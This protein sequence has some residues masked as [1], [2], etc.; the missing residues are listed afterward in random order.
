MG[1][2]A[3][4]N[5]GDVPAGPAELP[6][7][8]LPRVG[9]FMFTYSTNRRTYWCRPWMPWPGWTTR[10]RGPGDRQ[11]GDEAIYGSR[12][13]SALRKL[14][15]RFRFFH[16][17]PLS[18]FKGRRAELLRCDTPTLPPGGRGDRQ[19]LRRQANWLRELVPFLEDPK[20]AIVQAPQDYR[21]GDET[22]SGNV[23]CR[24][25]WVLPHRHGD[26]PTSATRSFSTAP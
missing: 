3:M 14:G 9:P 23:Q 8:H 24:V 4:V 17:A 25:S 16:V 5:S 11:P 6:E 19:R 22:C 21:D 18:G 1:R 20:M 12:F 26:Q 15:A 2:G 13:I 7:H 10:F